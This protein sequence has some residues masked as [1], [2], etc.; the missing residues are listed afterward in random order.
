MLLNANADLWYL[1]SCLKLFVWYDVSLQLLCQLWLLFFFLSL[2]SSGSGSE[3][4]TQT[5]KSIKSK[6]LEKSDNNSGSNDEDD[7]ESIGL[8]NVDGSDNG[9]GTQV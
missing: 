5:Q 8:N 6:S 3:S 1:P 2:Q 9:S 7:N 4:G